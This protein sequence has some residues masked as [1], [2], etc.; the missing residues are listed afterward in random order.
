[1]KISCPLYALGALPRPPRE[2][3]SGR[4][5]CLHLPSFHS[6]PFSLLRGVCILHV[7]VSVCVNVRKGAPRG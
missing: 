2:L 1:M 4:T 7:R 5:H 6:L 3:P